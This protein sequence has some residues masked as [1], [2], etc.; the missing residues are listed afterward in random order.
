MPNSEAVQPRAFRLQRASAQI[1]ATQL[2]QYWNARFPGDPLAAN[3][4][5]ITFN[6]DNNTVYVQAS[7]ADLEDIEALIKDWDTTESKAI[8]VVRIFPLRNAFAAE[9]AQTLANA[10]TANIVN[11]IAQATFTNPQAAAAG[12]TAQLGGGLGGLNAGAAAGA[13]GGALGGGAQGALGGAL[14]GGLA[15]QLAG[16]GLG[17]APGRPVLETPQ[18]HR[19]HDRESVRQ[20]HVRARIP[21]QPLP[22]R[23]EARLDIVLEQP[24]PEPDPVPILSLETEAEEVHQ[25]LARPWLVPS[26]VRAVSVPLHRE[27]P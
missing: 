7:R 23:L 27:S 15:G 21:R 22:E 9:L 12:G 19:H 18:I 25:R 24:P 3:Q 8:N 26:V 1:I 5:R 2:Q 16:G 13:L 6:A 20:V 17:G 4:M 10:L 14:G 11:P